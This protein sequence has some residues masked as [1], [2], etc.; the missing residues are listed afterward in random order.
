MLPKNI[1]DL[2]TIE[3]CG[4]F[5]DHEHCFV[6]LAAKRD[7]GDKDTPL[8]LTNAPIF[9]LSAD[10][11]I[12]VTEKHIQN[13]SAHLVAKDIMSNVSLAGLSGSYGVIVDMLANA[14]HVARAAQ[15]RRADVASHIDV[16]RSFGRARKA[17]ERYD[18]LPGSSRTK[19]PPDRHQRDMAR[20]YPEKKKIARDAI[21][22]FDHW[23]SRFKVKA[24]HEDQI[25]RWTSEL[26]GTPPPKLPPPYKTPMSDALFWDIV[27]NAQSGADS[28]TVL[29]IEDQMVTYTPKAIRDAA[30]IALSRLS[31]AYRNDIWALAY[32][33]QDGCSDDA[34]EDF[35]NWMILQGRTMFDGIVAAPDQFDPADAEG[36]DFGAASGLIQAFENAYLRR[37]G[38]PLTLPRMKMPKIDP[39]EERFED[40]LPNLTARLASA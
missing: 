3:Y 38:K 7:S 20:K 32:L 30:K 2:P 25:E 19:T 34:F 37:S 28:E 9:E 17:V 18:A 31:D 16:F 22:A 24:Q 14:G 35:R 36:A 12:W 5:E 39:D 11:L 40:L 29:N 26:N 33:L 15:I 23:A 10:L 4:L 27:A 1:I 6:L 21:D 13:N 8:E